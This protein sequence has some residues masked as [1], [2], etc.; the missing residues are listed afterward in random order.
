MLYYQVENK[1]FLKQ[2]NAFK[3]A[4]ELLGVEKSKTRIKEI[5][6]KTSHNKVVRYC[7]EVRWKD[8]RI[9][10]GENKVILYGVP[11]GREINEIE[12]TIDEIKVPG[13]PYKPR[14][15]NYYTEVLTDWHPLYIE[16]TRCKAYSPKGG[17]YM[18][19]MK[20][21]EL[22]RIYIEEI[23]I[24]FEDGNKELPHIKKYPEIEKLLREKNLINKSED[25]RSVVVKYKEDCLYETSI[26]AIPKR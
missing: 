1:N 25:S 24:V 18:R 26:K 14:E 20:E 23:N 3:Y 12:E 4:L 7:V 10:I 9:E 5:G 17:E 16:T 11:E 13:K 21:E 2:E 22:E 19:E 6:K 15:I 8:H